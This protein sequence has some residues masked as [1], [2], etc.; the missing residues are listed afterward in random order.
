VDIEKFAKKY[1]QWLS[2][3]GQKRQLNKNSVQECVKKPKRSSDTQNQLT[4]SPH[5]KLCLAKLR[6]IQNTAAQIVLNTTTVPFPA[7]APALAM[8]TCLLP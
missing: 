4:S 6:L 7:A 3:E 2:S 5:H 1:S 8:A